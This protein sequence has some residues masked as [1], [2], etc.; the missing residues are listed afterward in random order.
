MK[1]YSENGDFLKILEERIL[2]DGQ[3]PEKDVLK[4]DN[5]VNQRIDVA[6]LREVCG[7]FYN[8][9]K[10]EKI[11]KILTIEASGIAI[12][13]MAAQYFDCDVVFA[14][15]GEARNMGNDVYTAKV[16]SFTR[17]R[18]YDL[19]VGRRHI[20]KGDRLLIIDD[21]LAEGSALSSLCS[22]A[23]QAE[24]EVVGAGIL[25][26]KAYMTGG[27]ELREKGLRIESLA[28]IDRMDEDGIVFRSGN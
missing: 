10:N 26:E 17:N 8:R 22:I 20:S 11:D 23:G 6:F 12:A 4:V 3:V 1:K 18:V 14:K 19:S 24:A 5:F 15:K 16:T 13:C 2:K 27:R 28:M 9:F 7:E 25:I 21:F